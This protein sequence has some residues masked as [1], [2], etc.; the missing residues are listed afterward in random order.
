MRGLFMH[1][2]EHMD[3]KDKK[4]ARLEK[5]LKFVKNQM[6]S[7]LSLYD[8]AKQETDKAV[9]AK[10]E[11][12]SKLSHEFRT[13]M[14]ALMGYSDLLIKREESE[15]TKRYAS[16][17]KSATNRL[18]N[19]FNDLIE[20]SRIESG[21]SVSEEEEYDFAVLIN[22][23]MDSISHEV[24][25]K[26]LIMKLNFDEDLP[27]KLYGDFYH[28][29]Q[30]VSNLLDNA[31]KYTE[32]GYISLDIRATRGDDVAESGRK[33]VML[34][35]SVKDTGVGI[36]KKDKD[37][38]FDVFA[39]FNSKNPYANQGAGVGLTVAKYYSHKMHGDIFFKSVYGS[40][41]E[42]VC[43]V[44]QEI[45]DDS[46]LSE[47]YVYDKNTRR[48]IV[49]TAPTA[50][51]L[52][53][54]DSKVNL[55]VAKGLLEE[56][57]I[58]A[59]IAESGMEALKK[60]GRKHYDIIF[61][62]HMMPEMDGI[63]TMKNIRNKGN[64]CEDVPIIALTANA[65]DEARQMFKMEG[66]QDFLAKPI[67][68]T[69]LHDILLKWVPKDKIVFSDISEGYIINED[70]T[71]EGGNTAFTKSRLLK[72][73][74][75]LEVGLPYFGGNIKAYKATMES[76]LKDC[77]KKVGLIEKHFLAGDLKNYAIE[78]H[79]VKSVSASIGATTFSEL[80]KDNELKAKAEDRDYIESNGAFFINKYKEFINSVEQI[81]AEER[82]F[83]AEK[84]QELLNKSLSEEDGATGNG[85]SSGDGVESEEQVKAKLEE[86]KKKIEKAIE[87]IEDFESDAAVEILQS[88]RSPDMDA[89]LSE[90]L[91]KA[92]DMI[93][94]FEYDGAVEVLKSILK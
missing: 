1:A 27:R 48:Q 80:A 30:I 28:L 87:A 52:I 24:N 43:A 11:F 60:I 91:C 69:L 73:G 94:D 20:I 16:G 18:L 13:P 67:E 2:N 37:K 17:I 23:L 71:Y 90:K 6:A 72:E 86:L 85:A 15:I 54:D 92:S 56:Y 53:V 49:F 26:G 88:L 32:K 34:T 22:T 50:R 61:M 19:L 77:K 78:A 40:G 25:E 3:E 66:M 7:A 4:I 29:R 55:G 8:D 81:L 45:V 46:H 75:Y 36:R 58:N 44:T 12:M 84:E 70:L 65:T 83:E 14:N 47:S 76:I 51:V 31:V 9:K 89:D 79:S 64:W 10:G 62:D 5:E 42:F 59:D 82:H 57:G 39:Q 93:D 38:L 63:E 41:S 35:F 21:I 33:K 74:I 68:L